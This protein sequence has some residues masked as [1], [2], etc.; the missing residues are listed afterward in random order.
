M[1]KDLTL[2]QKA[3]VFALLCVGVLAISIIWF[4]G[5]SIS[6]GE[7]RTFAVAGTGEVEVVATKATINADFVGEGNNPEAAS[8]LLSEQSA[9]VFAELEDAGVKKADIKTQSVTSNP[10]YDYC[11]NYAANKIPEYCRTN[12][13]EAKIVGYIATQNFSISINEN[14]PLVEK[15]LGLLPSLGARNMNGPNWEVDNKKAI[16]EAR[17]KAVEEARMKAE[18]IAKSL[19]MDLGDAIYYSEDQGGGGYPVPMMYNTMSAKDSRMEMAAVS[20]PV[21]QGTDKVTV[22]VNITYELE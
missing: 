12:P 7:M 11:Y 13:S 4:L 18:G 22:N 8:N 21:S 16:Q 9:K 14:Q 17:E 3:G 2:L 1:T 5:K 20:I 6:Q 10:K 19:G 15:I